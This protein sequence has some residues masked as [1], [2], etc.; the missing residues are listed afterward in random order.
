MKQQCNS[1]THHRHQQKD[2]QQPEDEYTV[3]FDAR[4][5]IHAEDA[6]Q[7]VADGYD[8]RHRGKRHVYHQQLVS[9]CVQSHGQLNAIL[10]MHTFTYMSQ[11]LDQNTKNLNVH[12][13]LQCDVYNRTVCMCVQVGRR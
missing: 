6:Q 1:S 13:Y 12:F 9:R 10:C 8:Q 2:A 5:E 11:H 7:E 3:V 4:V